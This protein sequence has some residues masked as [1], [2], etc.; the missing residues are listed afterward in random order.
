[1]MESCLEGEQVFLH[2]LEKWREAAAWTML[3]FGNIVSHADGL[4]SWTL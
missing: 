4:P 1:M 2:R 3:S